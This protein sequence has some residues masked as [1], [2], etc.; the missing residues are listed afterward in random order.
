MPKKLIPVVINRAGIDP[1]IKVNLV[2]KEMRKKLI[3]VITKFRVD[4]VE[5]GDIS[6]AIITRGGVNIKEVNPK[7]ME[8]KKMNGLYFIG[9]VLDVDGY[10]GGFNLQ[11]A[12]STAYSCAK[13]ISELQSEE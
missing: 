3:D 5:K 1:R 11:I 10:T 13:Y 7:T 12:W 9:E 8:S 6:E 2:T 4:I